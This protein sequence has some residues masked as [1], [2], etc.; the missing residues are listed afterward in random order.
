MKIQ[1]SLCAEENI[2]VYSAIIPNKSSTRRLVDLFNVVDF[3]EPHTDDLH[4]TIL[5][6]ENTNRVFEYPASVNVE[7]YDAIIKEFVTW[8]GHNGQTY[9]VALLD[10]PAI[11]KANSDWRSLGYSSTFPEYRPHITVKKD[12]DMKLADK[13]LPALNEAAENN[14]F[15][16]QFGSQE[17]KPLDN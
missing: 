17:I 12:F 6:S 11:M 13:V 10:S 7:Q 15:V 1:V 16:I 4:C 9:L 8:T 2:G 5:F 3:I 14:P